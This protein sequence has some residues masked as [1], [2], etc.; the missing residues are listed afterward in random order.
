MTFRITTASGKSI[1]SLND[2][3]IED[4]APQPKISENPPPTDLHKSDE[5]TIQRVKNRCSSKDCCS[6]KSCNCKKKQV[7]NS[8]DIADMQDTYLTNDTIVTKADKDIKVL[9]Q[10]S[11]RQLIL[12]LFN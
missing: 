4:L 10:Q 7:W 2:M 8:T 1:S 5:V 3:D 12:D 9:I 6:S 11:E